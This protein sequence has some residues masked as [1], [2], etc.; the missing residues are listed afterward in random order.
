MNPSVPRVQMVSFIGGLQRD[1][2]RNSRQY[3]LREEKQ[4]SVCRMAWMEMQ[5]V[6]VFPYPSVA[7]SRSGPTSNLSVISDRFP[8]I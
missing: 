3:F 4:S 2:I 1:V 7:H 5:A 6:V 8:F